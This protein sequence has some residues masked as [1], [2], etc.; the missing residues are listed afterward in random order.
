[1]KGKGGK[2]KGNG[3]GK[4]FKGNN[5]K[6]IGKTSHRGKGKGVVCF[7]LLRKKPG[8]TSR[9]CALNRVNAVEETSWTDT[10]WTET[11]GLKTKKTSN[12]GETNT[13][14]NEETSWHDNLVCRTCQL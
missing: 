11:L 9:E 3:K 2:S 6:G 7:H 12:L 5:G 1:M 8:H 13:G 10:P 14:E 4:D